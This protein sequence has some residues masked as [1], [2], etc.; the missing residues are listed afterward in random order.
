MTEI[1]EKL[2]GIKGLVNDDEM[3]RIK[4]KMQDPDRIICPLNKRYAQ[5]PLVCTGYQYVCM[6]LNRVQI[7][8]NHPDKREWQATY[9]SPTIRVLTR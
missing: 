1:E 8:C 3:A 2:M 4:V 9:S 6:Y 7:V 5:L